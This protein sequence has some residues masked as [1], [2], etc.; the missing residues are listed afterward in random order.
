MNF[1]IRYETGHFDKS[2][3]YIAMYADTPEVLE[4]DPR[5]WTPELTTSVMAGLIDAVYARKLEFIRISK[6]KAVR[7]V[8]GMPHSLRIVAECR[9]A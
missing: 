5:A 7:G 8:P 4:A 6:I 2:L 3:V 1:S 9:A